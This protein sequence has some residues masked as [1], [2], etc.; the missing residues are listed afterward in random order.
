VS[1][2]VS[3]GG[4]LRV[5][6]TAAWIAG[7]LVR[8]DQD[9]IGCLHPR[10]GMPVSVPAVDE[11][12]DGVL[13]VGHAAEDTAADRLAVHDREPCLHLVQPTGAGGG[14][15]EVDPGMRAQPNLHV[16]MRLSQS[17]SA[18]PSP[19][20]FLGDCVSAALVGHRC[21]RAQ[22]R[23]LRRPLAAGGQPPRA[24]IRPRGHRR[25]RRGTPAGQAVVVQ[26]R[27][28]PAPRALHHSA[29]RARSSKPSVAPPTSR[30]TSGA[31]WSSRV[32]CAPS[33][34]W[35]GTVLAGP[36]PCTN[37]WSDSRRGVCAGPARRPRRAGA[38]PPGWCG[39]ATMP[40]P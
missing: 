31:S 23:G 34:E 36:R 5:A 6:A 24:R 12:L 40:V 2:F 15:V 10:E 19:P 11:A 21:R 22:R 20:R 13:E 3:S 32:W 26:H 1:R 29:G 27:R 18:P 35:P 14:E 7:F 9:F 25:R 8:M 33:G 4:P 38:D 16:R 37:G 17:C 39:R 28:G 30:P